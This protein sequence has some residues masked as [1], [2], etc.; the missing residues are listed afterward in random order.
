MKKGMEILTRAKAGSNG[1][2]KVLSM[3]PV[4]N[5]GTVYTTTMSAAYPE[6]YNTW[7]RYLI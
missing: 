5:V 7:I 6:L 3:F 1:L 2:Y 4:F